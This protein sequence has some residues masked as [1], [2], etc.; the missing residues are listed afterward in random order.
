MK[1][2]LAELA[3][4]KA[5]LDAA[6]RSTTSQI[7]KIADRLDRLDQHASLA[8]ETTGSIATVSPTPASAPAVESPKLTDRI[9]PDWIVQDVRGGRALVQSRHG[10]FFDVGAG[11]VLPGV[12]RVEPSSGRTANGSSSP[13]AARSR[14]GA[15]LLRWLTRRRG[16]TEP[17]RP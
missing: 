6:S 15:D 9:L 5:G 11:S 17:Y 7:A 16:A 10:G 14:P 13:R 12:G 4:I 2:Q 3:T 8:T 1:Q